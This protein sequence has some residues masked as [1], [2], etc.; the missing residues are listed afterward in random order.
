MESNGCEITDDDSLQYSQL[1]NSSKSLMFLDHLDCYIDRSTVVLHEVNTGII[2]TT[3]DFEEEQEIEI[4][5]SDKH[6][7]KFVIK[8]KVLQLSEPAIYE[9][10]SHSPDFKSI[11][12]IK[13]PAADI[14]KT[15]CTGA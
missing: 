6:F 11:F 7:E 15:I 10:I 14:Q 2:N 13:K 4:D 12:C 3:N 8:W 9:K 5:Q 1:D